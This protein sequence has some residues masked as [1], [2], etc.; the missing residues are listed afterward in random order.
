ME[1]SG[2]IP[3]IVGFSVI[4]HFQVFMGSMKKYRNHNYIIIKYSDKDRN[5]T[6]LSLKR[7]TTLGVVDRWSGTVSEGS[8]TVPVVIEVSK[9]NGYKNI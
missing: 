6:V 7:S 2:V 1:G 5:G 4:V 3:V 8:R 9:R